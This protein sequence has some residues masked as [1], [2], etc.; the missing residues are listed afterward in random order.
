MFLL[1]PAHLGCRGQNPESRKMVVCVC[2]CVFCEDAAKSPVNVHPENFYT[3]YKNCKDLHIKRHSHIH[4]TDYLHSYNLINIL[5]TNASVCQSK[6]VEV[7]LM[8]TMVA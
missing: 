4:Y 2:V 3:Q 1:V 7:L 8:R 5:K 6:Q